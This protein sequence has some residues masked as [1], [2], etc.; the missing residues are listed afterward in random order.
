MS[1]NTLFVA[2]G[3]VGLGIGAWWLCNRDPLPGGLSEGMSPED[4]DPEQLEIGTEVEME[5]VG[6]G[7]RDLAQEIAMDH[8]VE[9]EDY[10]TLLD[11]AGL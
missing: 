7:N 3:L 2:A 1:R 5:H 6:P 9:R 8:L 10:Y 11:E 4:F